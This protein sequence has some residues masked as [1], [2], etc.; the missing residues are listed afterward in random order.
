MKGRLAGRPRHKY[1]VTSKEVKQSLYVSGQARR[2]PGI[3]GSHNF[4]TVRT[5]I[6]II[7]IIISSSSSSS[8][9]TSINCN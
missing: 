7:I 2:A 3:Q 1:E 4:Q 8:S 9:S 6:I 5:L